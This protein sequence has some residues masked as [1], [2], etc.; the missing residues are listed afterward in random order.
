MKEIM[1][2]KKSFFALMPEKK[3]AAYDYAKKYM[4]FLD[5]SK[6]ER[7]AVR[8]TVK[9]AEENGYTEFRMGDKLEAGGKY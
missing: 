8:Y 2:D 9:L 5:N 6:T 1:Y 4:D 3:D 7:D